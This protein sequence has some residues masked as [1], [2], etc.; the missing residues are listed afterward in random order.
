MNVLTHH[1]LHPDLPV[2]VAV[3]LGVA[4]TAVASG[5]RRFRTAFLLAACTL[6]LAGAVGIGA[7]AA[8]RSG[9]PV[10][11]AG[12]SLPGIAPGTAGGGPDGGIDGFS[13]VLTVLG[14]ALVLL[15]TAARR[16]WSRWSGR[17]GGKRNGY[18]EPRRRGSGPESGKRFW[19]RRR[20]SADTTWSPD[21]AAVRWT[22]TP[23]PT[24]R[25]DLDGPGH[26]AGPERSTGAEHSTAERSTAERST[27][28]GQPTEPEAT[29][30]GDPT[31]PGTDDWRPFVE[32]D[33]RLPADAAADWALFGWGSHAAWAE[34]ERGADDPDSAWEDAAEDPAEAGSRWDDAPAYPPPPGGSWRAR[35][36]PFFE[37]LT[38]RIERILGLYLNA[39]TPRSGHPA[40]ID[41]HAPEARHFVCALTLTLDLLGGR[42]PAAQM[43]S[44]VAA[45]RETE[46]RWDVV[47]TR[48]G[49]STS[50]TLVSRRTGGPGVPGAHGGTTRPG[51]A[52]HRIRIPPRPPTPPTQPA[53]PSQPAP[54]REDERDRRRGP[55]RRRPGEHPPGGPYFGR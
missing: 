27:A 32:D 15:G 48:A 49:L 51:A 20:E 28:T 4:L 46:R 24:P 18:R 47:G 38:A 36:D 14:A 19:N 42:A 39:V 37:N 3:F 43:D 40:R 6:L 17:R 7:L 44:L 34:A 41:A 12:S 1:G 10:D 54:P 53:P 8:V 9:G 5:L 55:A 30:A 13:L 16:P 29:S 23:L 31:T 52:R 45:V 25:R 35:E 26:P 11:G 22:H 50:G 21:P 33:W 2:V